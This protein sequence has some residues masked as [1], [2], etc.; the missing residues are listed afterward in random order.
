MWLASIAERNGRAFRNQL[1]VVDDRCRLTYGELAERSLRLASGLRRLGVRR[2]DQV[3]LLSRNRAEM[4][5]SYLALARVGAAAVPV[6]HGLVGPE[7]EYVLSECSVAAVLGEGGHFAVDALA[8]SRL[9]IDFDGD[10]YRSL[11]LDEEIQPMPESS[12]GEMAAILFTSATTGKPK[13]A[14]LSQGSLMHTSLSWL[15]SA[16]P[17]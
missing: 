4:L 11:V 1:A 13:G 15:A 6:N 9:T 3:V 5:E 16:R 2:G 10:R 7:L 14:V 8:G 12:L 17:A